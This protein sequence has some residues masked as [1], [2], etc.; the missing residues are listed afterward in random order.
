MNKLTLIVP[1]FQRP[2]RTLRALECVMAQDMDGWDAY[3]VGDKCPDFQK[4]IDDGAF[5]KY[6]EDSKTKGNKLCAFNMPFHYGFW[7][8]QIRNT[9]IKLATSQYIIFLDNDDMIK[10]SHFRNYYDA[11]KDTDYDFVYMNTF[12]EP[13]EPNGKIRD[14]QL[15][16]G[17]IGHHEIIVK[18]E[19]L[20]KIPQ[21]TKEYEHDWTMINNMVKSGA[22]YCKKEVEPTYIVKGLGDLRA[23]VID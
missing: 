3:F 18:T 22:K 20:Q 16:K 10:P 17:K 19:L 4:L 7:G 6:I 15:E 14:A 1:C 12:I 23:D 2:Q 11:I 21:Q 8:Y 13:I 5:N 9:V